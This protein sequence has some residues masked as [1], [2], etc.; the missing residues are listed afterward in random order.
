MNIDNM[1]NN[2]LNSNMPSPSV[3]AEAKSAMP[4]KK[5]TH[6]RPLW[7]KLST[8]VA[9]LLIVCVGVMCASLVFGGDDS[10]LDADSAPS[11]ESG[12][13]TSPDVS[14]GTGDTDGT[15]DGYDSYYAYNIVNAY[16]VP[17]LSLDIDYCRVYTDELGNVVYV[18]ESYL[19]SSSGALASLHV[20]DNNYLDIDIYGLHTLEAY[21]SIFGDDAQYQTILGIEVAVWFSDDSYGS[22]IWCYGGQTEQYQWFVEIENAD[23]DTASAIVEQ[24]LVEVTQ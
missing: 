5:P 6:K 22:D 8:S 4:D 20:V 24:W 11:T 23:Q 1:I 15:I 19:D 2:S 13:A 3:L 7:L 9:S 12:T 18:L 14:P 17:S 21:I 10:M 16:G